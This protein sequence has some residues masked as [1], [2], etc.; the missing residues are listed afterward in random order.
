M[1]RLALILA[2]LPTLVLADIT[3]PARVI[4]GDTIEIGSER[5]R[6]HGI[7]APE[8]DQNC[9]DGDGKVYACGAVA[10]KA[11]AELVR[12]QPV[13]CKGNQRDRY[14]RLIA[15]CRVGQTNLNSYMVA[16]GMAL[17]YR[18]YSQEYVVYEGQARS[19]KRGLWAGKFVKPWE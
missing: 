3:G 19:K 10:T 15:V 14:G 2:L 18:K 8:S 11:L 12:D 1:L 6:L 16:T 9:Q 17:A 7:D 13:T 4:D 5:I